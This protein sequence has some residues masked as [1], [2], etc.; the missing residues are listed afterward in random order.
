MPSFVLG[1]KFENGLRIEGSHELAIE[2]AKSLPG[3]G[4]V[5]CL[6]RGRHWAIVGNYA[7]GSVYNGQVRIV[8]ATAAD[9]EWFRNANN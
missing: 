4:Y 3:V 6:R 7:D 5:W 9:W 8:P 1:L 2:T